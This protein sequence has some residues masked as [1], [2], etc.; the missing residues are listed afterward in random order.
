MNPNEKKRDALFKKYAD[1]L[2]LLV[3]NKLLKAKGLDKYVYICPVCLQLFEQVNQPTNPLTLEDAPPKSLGGKANILTCKNCNNVAGT[4]IDVHLSERLNEL[5]ERQLLPGTELKVKINI[6]GQSYAATLTVEHDGKMKIFH[7]KKNNNPVKLEKAMEQV[8]AGTVVDMDYL[9]SRVIPERIEY[10]LLKTAYLLAFQYFG[11]SLMLDTCYDD[12]RKQIR[13]PEQQTYPSGFW[14]Q[15]TYPKEMAG[16][17]FITDTS[18]ESLFIFFN[19]KTAQTERMFAVILPLPVRPVA[20]VIRQL[21]QR[22][23]KEKE[24]ELTLY[25]N[26]PADYLTKIENIKAMHQ[27]IDARKPKP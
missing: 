15:P 24:F 27:W 4:E 8:T 10:A 22:F 17:Y 18:L 26:T 3:K 2:Q 1:N 5:D 6:D 25:P 9:K 23:E 20:A 12:V 21:A 14:F 7:S 13:H 16:C 19:V 11:Y